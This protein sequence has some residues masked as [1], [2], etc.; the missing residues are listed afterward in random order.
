MQTL[1]VKCFLKEGDMFH[2]MHA[3]GGCIVF[4]RFMLF[5]LAPIQVDVVVK[6]SLI[7]M[8]P[9]KSDYV[10]GET[11]VFTVTYEVKTNLVNTN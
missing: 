9:D 8:T 10:E 4:C 3:A 6:N 11:V 7:S 5:E 2:N 1:G